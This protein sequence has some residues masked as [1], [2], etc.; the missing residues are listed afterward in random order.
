MS[1]QFGDTR[2]S[3]ILDGLVRFEFLI[4]ESE[5]VSEESRLGVFRRIKKSACPVKILIKCWNWCLMKS[6]KITFP[7]PELRRRYLTSWFYINQLW[8]LSSS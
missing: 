6:R 8:Y 2:L 3:F 7:G 5:F 1:R 4:F